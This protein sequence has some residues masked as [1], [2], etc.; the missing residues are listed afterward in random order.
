M[1]FNSTKED[2]D[3]FLDRLETKPGGDAAQFTSNIHQISS[4]VSGLTGDAFEHFRGTYLG[5]V[6]VKELSHT[7][8]A[9]FE[10]PDPKGTAQRLR[11]VLRQSTQDFSRNLAVI[12][13]LSKR[14]N[15][16]R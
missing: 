13:S 12:T 11:T 1:A 6:S 9:A 16:T 3:A 5:Y 10:D 15:M 8:Q 7:L 2:L 14:L 4:A